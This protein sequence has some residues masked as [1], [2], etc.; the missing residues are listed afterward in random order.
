[1]R[2]FC[3]LLASSAS[4]LARS[5]GSSPLLSVQGHDK[6]PKPEPV[7]PDPDYSLK[8]VRYVSFGD[9]W[10]S[11]VNYGGPDASVEYNYPDQ[12]EIC[13]CRRVKEAWPNQ[14]TVDLN[15][16]TNS[17]SDAAPE[18]LQGRQIDLDF[19]ACH[20]SYFPDIPDQVSRL[21]KTYSPDFGTLMIGGNPGGF[22]DILYDCVFWPERGK[23][24]GPEFPDPE[25]ECFKALE[26]A[27]DIVRSQWFLEG[28]LLSISLILTAPMVRRNPHFKL[29]VV[30]YATL[31][32]DEDEACD[33]LSFGYWSGQ[34]PLL[35]KELR[36]E[37]NGVIHAGRKLY[38]RL[39]NGPLFSDQVRYIDIDH[40]FN[41]RRF[42]EPTMNGTLEQQNENSWLYNFVWPSCIPLMA[43][44]AM[45][46]LDPGHLHDTTWPTF[47]RKCGGLLD[48]GEFQRPF[49][50]KPVAHKAIKDYVLQE[51]AKTPPP[52]PPDRDHDGIKGMHEEF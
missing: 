12:D 39:L 15:N 1:M 50:P 52:P 43:E 17:S 28:I 31:F 20:A 29:Y 2:L 21:N 30:S 18:W 7:K 44:D 42:C 24:Y 11:G 46:D 10:S 37:I 51:L 19:L 41:G 48:Y 23:D 26:R 38:D 34:K 45:A 25:G 5:L 9:S 32:N 16:R 13:R 22:A 40:V 6:D 33:D 35:K 8:Y 4:S 14:L 3:L 49:H 27:N 36:Q 47:C